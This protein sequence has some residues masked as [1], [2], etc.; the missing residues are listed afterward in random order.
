MLSLFSNPDKKLETELFKLL[1]SKINEWNCADI[2]AISLYVESECDNPFDTTVTLGFNTETN[3][4]NN[5]LHASDEQEARWNYAFWLQNEEL[6][7]GIGETKD[8]FKK[9]LV[10]KGYGYYS[11][12][13]VYNGNNFDELYKIGEKAIA[14][15]VRILISIVQK[16]HSCGFIREK[17]GREIPILVHELEYYETIASQ[18]IEANS[19]ELVT[20]FVKFCKGE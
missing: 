8:C 17:F 5:L 15:F 6:V 13:E 14:N 4:N 1:K 3:Y 11:Y 2:Y 16:L 12:N 18:N 9:W 10:N 7:F 20:D 19:Q